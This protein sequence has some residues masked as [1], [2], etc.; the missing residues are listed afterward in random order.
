[1]SYLWFCKS[2]LNSSVIWQLQETLDRSIFY[3]WK[4]F[5]NLSNCFCCQIVLK[6]NCKWLNFSNQNKC[7]Y[8]P[9]CNEHFSVFSMIAF[10]FNCIQV[11][12]FYIKIGI[13][14][15]Q[16]EINTFFFND[17]FN[18]VLYLQSNIASWYKGDLDFIIFQYYKSYKYFLHFRNFIN[19]LLI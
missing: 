3:Y 15:Y 4:S 10:I 12:N 19:Q 14:S 7:F 9:N 6:R 2:K 13:L 11:W 17:C 16:I 18:F 5:A 8:I 1:M